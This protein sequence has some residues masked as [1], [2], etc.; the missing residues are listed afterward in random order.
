MAGVMGAGAA[1]GG[2]QVAVAGD[3]ARIVA[4][5]PVLYRVPLAEALVDAGHG[6]H[7][8]FELVTCRII[9]ADGIEGVGY[10]Y[11]GGTGGTA[12]RALL[13]DDIAP[14]LH[15]SDAQGLEALAA[16][17]RATLH[18]LG[19][20]GICGFAIAAVDIA[21]WDIRCKR[22]G[23]PLWQVA[24]G[25]DPAV[26]C[27]RG[28]ID[29]GY[30]DDQLLARVAAEFDAGHSGI[31]LK[32]G[33]PDIAT[34]IRRVR[35]V[36]ELIGPERA[37]MAD[38]NYSW[39]AD[40]AITFARGVEDMDLAWFEEPVA[41]DDLAAYASVAAATPIP[42]ASG[43]NLR[44]PA[45][46]DQAIA[47]DAIAI[48]QPDASNIGGITPWLEVA[49]RA[50]ATGKPVASHGM[51]EL[52]VSLMAAI[53]NAAALEIHSFPIDA[54][55]TN[56]TTVEQGQTLAPNTPGTGVTFDTQL[57]KTHLAR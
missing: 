23:K 46:F 40:A 51:H 12:I 45:E 35:A 14:L 6:L 50:A 55:T 8:H 5:E 37:L 49:R 17:M 44:T 47:H 22:L 52:H 34:D 21:L 25:T 32:V 2:E 30:S 10:T 31:K 16:R 29:L 33:R 39:D 41:H 20:G 57:L 15:G 28:L 54:Y 43:E 27:Y 26:R 48:L 36:R 56:P 38:A 11:T 18:Y 1:I 9:C 4:I 3:A 13:C 19:L 42:L 53:P 24:G 7:T